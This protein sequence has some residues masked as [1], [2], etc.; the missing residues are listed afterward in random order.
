MVVRTVLVLAVLL[1]VQSVCPCNARRL[2]ET[3]EI[4]ASG[5]SFSRV[6]RHSGNAGEAVV[7]N[8]K[9]GIDS[10]QPTIPGHSPSIGH[11]TPPT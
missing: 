6:C 1:L 10:Y 2:V 5:C 3:R 7:P 9:N 11:N 4:A 8:G